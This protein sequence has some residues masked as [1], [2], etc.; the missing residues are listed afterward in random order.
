M[1]KNEVNLKKA[2]KKLG[3]MLEQ[4]SVQ[5][6]LEESA[7]LED[8]IVP[9]FLDILEEVI[10]VCKEEDFKNTQEFDEKYDI[11]EF[12]L[13]GFIGNYL[14][15]PAI[16]DISSDKEVIKRE[17]KVMEEVIKQ[18]D[19]LDEQKQEYT[20]VIIRDKHL[21]GE[22][23]E[24]KEQLEKFIEE[25]PANSE[26]YELKCEWTNNDEEISNILETAY[27]NNT[28]VSS[29][30]YYER[31]IKYNKKDKEKAKFFKKMLEEKQEQ[32]VWNYDEEDYDDDLDLWSDYDD[33]DPEMWDYED[34]FE[35][36]Y[37][38][39][40]KQATIEAMREF[41]VDKIT[42][43]KTIEKYIS[44]KPENTLLSIVIPEVIL[45]SD[46][47]I[48]N[49]RKDLKKY[50]IENYE[51]IVKNNI[52]YLP[53]EIYQ[54]LNELE[55]CYIEYDINNIHGE[56]VKNLKKYILLH[57]YGIAFAGISKNKLK[58]YI[59]LAN[60]IRKFSSKKENIKQNEEHNE[61]IQFFQG[62]CEIYGAIKCKKT[63]EIYNETYEEIKEDEFCK[64]LILF[65]SLGRI[66]IKYNDEGKGLEFIYNFVLDIEDANKI[67]KSQK[68]I[69]KYSKEEYM[70]YGKGDFIKNTE[71][72][73]KI[74]NQFRSELFDDD[75]IYEML[76]EFFIT[77]MIEKRLGNKQIE[78][79]VQ[80]MIK[81]L[82]QFKEMGFD[83]NVKELKEGIKM[84][85]EE[86]PM[87]I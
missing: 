68:E 46:D 17:I 45:K 5:F 1:E 34:D 54:E 14:D 2:V 81:E 19:L 51:K 21:I 48:E 56:D 25:Y 67:I 47:E 71:G 86:I 57:H 29:D 13:I 59:P 82:N 6:N 43:N 49:A 24:A 62:I 72:F 22:E 26:A 4:W 44:E 15:F 70:K 31:A 66:L 69:K 18:F 35:D 83:I 37:L 84:I 60:E 78:K 20:L 53:K 27:T 39:E 9:Q 63:Y 32:D 75:T 80:K 33:Y 50:A 79:E 30:E 40:E 77:Y 11:F 76:K 12:G 61:K 74:A 87:W 7:L 55:E 85:G 41:F 23:K 52:L 28:F 42:K 64:L 73:K 36:Y 38:E 16:D 10:R 58:I 65:G 8:R 3:K